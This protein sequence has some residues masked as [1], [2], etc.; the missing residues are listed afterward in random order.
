MRPRD[1]SFAATPLFQ[2]SGYREQLQANTRPCVPKRAGIAACYPS[3]SLLTY[4]STDRR[5]RPLRDLSA[6]GSDEVIN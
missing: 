6:I 1:R 5:E 3:L 4:A 2:K